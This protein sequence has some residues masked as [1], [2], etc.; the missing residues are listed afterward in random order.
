MVHDLFSYVQQTERGSL[1]CG[2]WCID[3]NNV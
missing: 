2:R 1:F 3:D